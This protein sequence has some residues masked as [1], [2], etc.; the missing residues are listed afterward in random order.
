MHTGHYTA[1]LFNSKMSPF[2]PFPRTTL[3]SWPRPTHLLTIQI[4]KLWSSARICTWRAPV[5]PATSLALVCIWVYFCVNSSNLYLYDHFKIWAERLWLLGTMKSRTTTTPTQAS[6]RPPV[7]SPKWSGTRVCKSE[8]V[9]PP[10]SLVPGIIATL[11]STIV[12][13]ETSSANSLHKY[14]IQPL[15][16]PQARQIHHRLLLQLHRLLPLRR[17]LPPELV[18]VARAVKNQPSKKYFSHYLI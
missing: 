13:L 16:H 11:W 6:A 9:W 1:L 12:Q 7:T 3:T 4:L 10:A 17:L 15:V 18:L 2:Q 5:L 14:A 8:W